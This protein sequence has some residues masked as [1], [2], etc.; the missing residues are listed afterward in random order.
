MPDSATACP[1]C[2]WRGVSDP[3]VI[4]GNHYISAGAFKFDAYDS[5]RGDGFCEM[6]INWDDGPGS[7]VFLMNQ[8]K[9]KSNDPQF[10]VGAIKVH[11]N[12]YEGFL[13]TYI[14]E[15]K[16]SWERREIASFL[17]DKEEPVINIYHGNILVKH[18]SEG[19]NDVVLKVLKL[20]VESVLATAAT[21]LSQIVFRKDYEKPE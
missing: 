19:S 15:G 21:Q 16:L 6:S 2:F 13:S 10:K 17:I 18:Y 4:Q 20:Q 12:S 14:S 9:E 1:D 7:L 3:N 8:R 5:S 11:R